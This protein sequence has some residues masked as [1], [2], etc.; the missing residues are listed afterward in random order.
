MSRLCSTKPSGRLDLIRTL[1]RRRRI[2]IHNRNEVNQVLGLV[3]AGLNDCEVSRRTGI[4]R[5]TVLD[6]RNGRL[7]HNVLSRVNGTPAQCEQNHSTSLDRERYAY[8]L[9][10]YL[11]D[12]CLSRGRRG[13]WR[14]RIFTDARYP[15]IIDEC[16]NAMESVFPEKSAHRLR[17]RSCACVELSMW[18]KQ[19]P[20]LFPQHGPGRKHNRSIE[21]VE[22]QREIVEEFPGALLRGLIHSDGCRIIATERRGDYVR[23]APRYVFSNMSADIRKLFCDTCD[24]I[25]VRWT[26]PSHKTVAI[27]RLESVGR[28]DRFVGPKA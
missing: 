1:V 25:G 10:M 18:S 21:L 8:L 24:A 12:G 17:R 3:Q 11:G 16:C 4:P 15:G 14:L 27:Y 20:R 22:W 5:R 28:L 13:V 2:D 9:G 26:L 23:R 6:W 7:P 19:W